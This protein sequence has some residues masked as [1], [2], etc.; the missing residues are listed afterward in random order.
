MQHR[1]HTE[2][3][4]RRL[5]LRTPAESDAAIVRAFGSDE[6]ATDADALRFIHW[7][8][9]RTDVCVNFYIWLAH[10]DQMIGRVYF[11]NKAELN[12]ELEIGYGISEPYRNQGYATEAAQ[13]A[14]PFIF[15][16]AGQDVISAIVKPENLPSRRVIEKLGF[17]HHGIRTVFD[18]GADCDF[19]YFRLWRTSR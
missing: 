4:T 10:T 5:L 19:E 2:I 16:K 11:H 15:K 1:L 13:A 18:N 7:I 6:F 17:T 8:N 14:I 9:S 12:G 3:R